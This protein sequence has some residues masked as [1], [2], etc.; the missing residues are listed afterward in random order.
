MSRCKM[1]CEWQKLTP[2]ISSRAKYLRCSTVN[3][4]RCTLHRLKRLC[5]QYP[6]IIKISGDPPARIH[7]RDTPHVM[8]HEMTTLTA[9]TRSLGTVRQAHPKQHRKQVPKHIMS[10]NTASYTA[11]HRIQ[12]L[13]DAQPK[14][15]KPQHETTNTTQHHQA[16]HQKQHNTTQTPQKNTKKQ[17]NTAQNKTKQ[18]KTK[19]N[20]TIRYD[21]IRYKKNKTTQSKTESMTQTKQKPYSEEQNKTHKTQ[22]KGKTHNSKHHRKKNGKCKWRQNAITIP[23]NRKTARGGESETGTLC[24]QPFPDSDIVTPLKSTTD[25][26]PE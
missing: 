16:H 21:T 2:L 1:L 4:P 8:I 15:N 24:T 5:S 14:Q 3:L 22:S 18:N 7:N 20:N 9:Q 19:Q 12:H 10:S 26:A 23:H 25:R 6:M 11:Q 17:H 13:K